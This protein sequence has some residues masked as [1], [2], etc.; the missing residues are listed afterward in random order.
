MTEALL[1]VRNLTVRYGDRAGHAAVDG[2]TFEVKPG[3]IVAIVG[4]SGS[5]KSSVSLSI[6]SL[7]PATAR[8]AGSIIFEGR[9]LAALDR[10]EM[11]N[12]RG[13]RI[14]MIFQ[15]P[16]TCLNPVLSISRQITE[17]LVR[18]RG[19]S[20]VAA[21]ER[22]LNALAEV[23]ISEPA[24]VMSSF[25]HELSGGLRQ[26]VMIAAALTL[27][28]ALLI[29]DEPTTALDVTVQAQVLELLVD[30]RNRTGDGVLL[31]THDIGVVA[32]IADRVVVMQAGRIVEQGPWEEVLFSPR[33][34]YTAGLISAHAAL[35]EALVPEASDG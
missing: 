20:L 13:N 17:G 2:A 8:V 28:P 33:E 34:P 35:E 14:G 9:D 5:G 19:H 32:E 27:D 10:R 4:E 22:A 24:R 3:E 18:H 26:R 29:A 15:E 6:M 23:G 1:A 12:I 21:R 7:L 30:I 16:M 11:E 25:P 31:I